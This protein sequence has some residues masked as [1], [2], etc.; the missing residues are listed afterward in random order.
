MKIKRRLLNEIIK[1]YLNESMEDVYHCLEDLL[2]AM[3]EAKGITINDPSAF[4]GD[5]EFI[6]DPDNPRSFLMKRDGKEIELDLSGESGY[7]MLGSDL[8]KDI[9]R[10]ERSEIE[11]KMPQFPGMPARDPVGRR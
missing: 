11:S 10:D 3:F 8:T 2:K 4:A 5:T 9:N 7:K 6:K 1:T